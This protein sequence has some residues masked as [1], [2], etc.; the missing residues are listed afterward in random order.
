LLLPHVVLQVDKYDKAEGYS[1][2]VQR[3]QVGAGRLW[4]GSLAAVLVWQ[5]SRDPPWLLARQVVNKTSHGVCVA[6]AAVAS[7][8][9]FL[10]TCLTAAHS[11]KIPSIHL[12]SLQKPSARV[13]PYSAL[14]QQF[15]TASDSSLPMPGLLV[16]ANPL[17][18]A[19]GAAPLCYWGPELRS[20]SVSPAGLEFMQQQVP[21]QQQQQQ[22][23]G[24]HH[25]PHLQLGIAQYG[26][27]GGM[28]SMQLLQ[29]HLGPAAV[30]SGSWA[31]AAAAQ[32]CW[33]DL[34]VS[35]PGVLANPLQAGAAAPTAAA[36]AG[37]PAQGSYMAMLTA[38]LSASPKAQ[39]PAAAAAGPQAS[40]Q[41]AC[42]IGP[43]RGLKQLQGLSNA[44]VVRTH[45]DAHSGVSQEVWQSVQDAGELQ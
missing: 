32:P 33:G 30:G 43:G 13:A 19:A 14:E 39:S 6:T 17:A 42:S 25:Q 45:S 10:P 21:G 9:A 16:S 28:G 3:K 12:P 36:A 26:A 2:R 15:P 8:L 4:T 41:R 7:L 18:A 34:S 35:L 22:Q 29:P 20:S 40:G 27:L 44:M 37:Q 23:E 31:A 24:Q 38:A 11:F 1:P 5:A